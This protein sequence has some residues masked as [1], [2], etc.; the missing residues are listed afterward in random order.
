MAIVL[1][2]VAACVVACVIAWTVWYRSGR[3]YREALESIALVC[4]HDGDFSILTDRQRQNLKRLA[5]DR[6]HSK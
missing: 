5:D 1:V 2:M 3:P 6:D 4:K